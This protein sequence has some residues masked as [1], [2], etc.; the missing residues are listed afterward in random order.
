[1]QAFYDR[2][3]ALEG[4]VT[5]L[6][7]ELEQIQSDRQQEAAVLAERLDEL[8]TLHQQRTGKIAKTITS[9]RRV[10]ALCLLWIASILAIGLMLAVDLADGK[11]DNAKQEMDII[12]SAAGAIGSLSVLVAAGG[13]DK[14]LKR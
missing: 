2:I 14:Q 10:L 13:A 6:K 7:S 3:Q 8:E 5:S 9:N 1:M 12:G 11:I 4:Q